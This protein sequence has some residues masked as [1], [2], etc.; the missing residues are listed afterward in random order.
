MRR[1]DPFFSA[2]ANHLLSAAV[3][4]KQLGNFNC[5]QRNIGRCKDGDRPNHSVRMRSWEPSC[6]LILISRSFH[7]YSV[8]ILAY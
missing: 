7:R 1:P 3:R 5:A 6:R 2:L 8:D 4:A